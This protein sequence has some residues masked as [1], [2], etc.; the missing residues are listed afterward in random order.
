MKILT[1]RRAKGDIDITEESYLHKVTAL[2]QEPAYNDNTCP[3]DKG[4][5]TREMAFESLKIDFVKAQARNVDPITNDDAFAVNAWT[6]ICN[7]RDN[8][9]AQRVE[10]PTFKNEKSQGKPTNAVP[11]VSVPLE[12][13]DAFLQKAQSC[14]SKFI[15]VCPELEQISWL[16]II[17][18]VWRLSKDATYGST[19][20][21]AF[22]IR[23]DAMLERMNDVIRWSEGN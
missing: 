23:A 20:Y 8:K 12:I 16:K 13:D 11:N 6:I 15:H 19:Y 4:K 5:T 14:R 18:N 2:L 1:I 21:D 3:K 22:F 17:Q 9:S 7:A 10:L